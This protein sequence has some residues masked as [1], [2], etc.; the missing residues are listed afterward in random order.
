MLQVQAGTSQK[1]IVVFDRIG[2]LTLP[3][4]LFYLISRYRVAYI[5]IAPKVKKSA[6]I[7]YWTD[8]GVLER[9]TTDAISFIQ[10]WET[11][12][13][14]LD[15]IERIYPEH[16]EHR[17]LF[18]SLERCLA[19]PCSHLAMKKA[20]ALALLPLMLNEKYCR[21]FTSL[22]SSAFVTYIPRAYD[23]TLY[24]PGLCTSE[25][26]CS[27][28]VPL[29]AKTGNLV[30]QILLKCYWVCIYVLFPLWILVQIG[31][32]RAGK[33]EKKTYQI[34]VRIYGT[35]WAFLQKSRQVDLLINNTTLTRDNTLFC[36]ETGISLDYLDEFMKREYQ[37]IEIRKMLKHCT[38]T[39]L[40]RIMVRNLLPGWLSGLPG[41]LSAPA[42]S[43]RT[44]LES[45]Y[46]YT[47]WNA[48]L[49]H[50]AFRH[51]IVY[52]DTIPAHVIRNLV[53]NRA[54]IETWYY[55]HSSNTADTAT[56]VSH[57]TVQSVI[58]S[59]LYYDHLV[60]W[61]N[62]M[63][64]YF[65]QNP[66]T[67]QNYDRF[68]CIY[69]EKALEFRR[70]D[71]IADFY[72]KLSDTHN[73]PKERP[74]TVIGVFDTTFGANV[75]LKPSDMIAFIEGIIRLIESTDYYV[76]FKTKLPEK[77]L[78]IYS[79][80]LFPYYRKLIDHP[81]CCLLN[82]INS[83]VSEVIAGSDLIISACFTSSAVESI[84]AGTP[85][86]YYDA[87]NKFSD[88]FYSGYPRLVAHSYPELEELVTH[89]LS[90]S[91]DQYLAYSRTHFKG[92]LDEYLDGRALTRFRKAV[93]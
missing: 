70:P 53:L 17:A 67:I 37:S 30:Y 23:R 33:K 59:Y 52:N 75:P 87:T 46:T 43:I 20:G 16:L 71:P 3:F 28:H 25:Q 12:N 47:I 10:L 72:T 18:L 62:R 9:I 4:I 44:Y 49:E 93:S 76:I 13:E 57:K 78:I 81:R 54:G 89:W 7:R 38:S 48:F 79:E 45:L 40:R 88:C 8:K 83:D 61:G 42:F 64:S 69:S 29:W 68:G 77:E 85:S 82:D 56:P 15:R 90:V 35:D 6:I 32:P 2:W 91:R 51:Y 66:N 41:L 5:E 34:G 73:F 92:D 11:N 1:K 58:Y 65:K 19:S 80:E 86:V 22:R 39:T 63:E 24:V 74:R 27:V 50:H 84:G 60:V 26:P 55:V 36:I 21:Y 14:V 31:V